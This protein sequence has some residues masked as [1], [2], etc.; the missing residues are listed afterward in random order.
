MNRS[1]LFLGLT[2]S[3][4]SPVWAEDFPSKVSADN[5][6]PLVSILQSGNPDQ[7]IWA[8]H[9]L[10]ELGQSAEGAAPVLV[11]LI[12]TGS[13]EVRVV[14]SIA[15]VKVDPYMRDFI[16]ILL[17]ALEKE[18][19]GEATGVLEGFGGGKGA[20]LQDDALKKWA[21]LTRREIDPK[22]MP[23]LVQ[24]LNEQDKDIR[25]MVLLV[26]GNIS[27]KVPAAF[28]ILMETLKDPDK[29]IRICVIG[30]MERIGAQNEKVVPVLLQAFQDSDKE[31]RA[32]AIVALGR[33]G[34]G[35]KEVVPA[36]SRGL[37][38][39]EPEVRSS[40]L[41]AVEL[42]GP[43]AKKTVPALYNLLGSEQEEERLRTVEVL[44][45]VD[46]SSASQGV[47]ILVRLLKNKYANDVLRLK[48]LELIGQLGSAAESAVPTLVE[49]LG[50]FNINLR[51]KSAEALSKIGSAALAALERSLKDPNPAVRSGSVQVLL[52]LPAEQMEVIPYLTAALKDEDR[53][54]RYMAAEG[55]RKLGSSAEPAIPDLVL[56]L[57]DP[58]ESIR[59]SASTALGRMGTLAVPA[60]TQAS[61]D[62]DPTLR[63]RATLLLEKIRGRQQ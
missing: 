54:V 43:A 47:P 13:P 41:N 3:F 59:S 31:V 38:D 29:E 26:L 50:D 35:S 4:V 33:M 25:I 6:Q 61:Q 45:K 16:P 62:P 5:P 10:G 51:T 39:G 12:K 11:R 21:S 32:R 46:P 23:V 22:I 60:L 20:G 44:L 2:L 15:L 42:L 1:L 30:I 27:L 14:A 8:A 28:P 52:M 58:E 55:L 63:N 37:G 7:Q 48:A 49:L 53:S 40:A 18:G 36:L 34:A 56:A 17:Q 9:V 57:K 19:A 24:A